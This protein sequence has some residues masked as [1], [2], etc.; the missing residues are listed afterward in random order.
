[1][2][3]L[4]KILLVCGITLVVLLAAGLVTL[5]VMFPPEKLKAMAVSYTKE[6]FHREI[7]FDDVSF[8]LIGVTLNNFALS[9][10]SSFEQGTFVKANKLQVKVA[11]KPLFQKKIEVSTVVLDGL[12]I[13]VIKQADGTFN[14]DSLT[15]AV[16][17]APEQAQEEQAASAPMNL[18]LTIGKITIT[19]CAFSYKDLQ[20]GMNAYVDRLNL[21]I[22]DF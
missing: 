7:S 5:K 13:N 2:K 6:N 20:S 15:A 18:D 22:R 9:E 17:S 3:K 14:F 12:E 4:I 19:D 8:N 1:M 16:S 10:E 21:E 11:L